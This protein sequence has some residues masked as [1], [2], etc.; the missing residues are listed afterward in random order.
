MARTVRDTNLET[1]TARLRL[2]IR[3]EPYGA[4][5]KRDL[6]LAT[7]AGAREAPGLRDGGKP[8]ADMPSIG[9][10]PRTICRSRWGCR[11]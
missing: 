11:A 8:M 9:L 2:P 3:T 6:R 7:G 4:A 5:S 10:A 1:R